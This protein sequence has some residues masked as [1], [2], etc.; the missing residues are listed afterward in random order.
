MPASPTT[1][2]PGSRVKEEIKAVVK[3]QVE[4]GIDIVAD[5]EISKGSF[6][7]YMMNRLS[8]FEAAETEPWPGPPDDFPEFAEMSLVA[9]AALPIGGPGLGTWSA[10]RVDC[11]PNRRSLTAWRPRLARCREMSGPSA[12]RTAK[13]LNTDL[14]NLKQALQGLSMKRRS[15][16]RSPSA[17]SS[18]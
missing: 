2:P 16:L 13:T 1:R 18:S 12:G 8:G 9:S 3:K 17:R 5:G 10:A 14:A 6:T 4:V 15:C 11:F 7:N